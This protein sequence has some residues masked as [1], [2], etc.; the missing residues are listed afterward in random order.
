MIRTRISLGLLIALLASGR[1]NASAQ[2]APPAEQVGAAVIARKDTTQWHS[3][4]SYSRLLR[5]GQRGDS[6]ASSGDRLA[7]IR[8]RLSRVMSMTA[9][10]QAPAL[11]CPMPVVRTS[12]DF[13]DEMPAVRTDSSV[14]NAISGTIRGCTNPLQPR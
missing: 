3:F 12:A 9:A 11:L 6:V 14:G 7:R 1:V 4:S 5:V 10:R 8:E 13:S 2:S